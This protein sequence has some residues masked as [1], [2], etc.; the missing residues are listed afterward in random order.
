MVAIETWKANVIR[1]CVSD[2]RWFGS[3]DDQKGQADAAEAYRKIVDEAVEATE[4]RGSYLVLDLHAY[5]APTERTVAFWKDAAAR[6]KA[7][8]GVLFA[9]LNEPHDISWQVW[10]DGGE[11]TD[12]PKKTDSPAENAQPL[13]SQ[14]TV[15]MQ[16]VVEAVRSAGAKNIVIIGGLDW[17]YDLSGVAGEFALTEP[18]GNGIMYDSHVYPWKRDWAGKV[19]AAAKKYP[20]L[21]GEVGCEEKPMP[22]IPVSAHEDPYTWAPDMIG[23]IQANHLNWTA[24]SFHPGATPRVIQDWN[25][26]PTPFWGA[27]VRAALLGAKFE[28][29]KMR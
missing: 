1:L 11:V 14:Q 27:F 20:L 4:T 9:L 25:Y 12:K 19:L 26:T 2:D 29:R 21:I 3:A 13:K 23:F 15:G 7:R 16:K 8:R 22:F 18:G 5:R 28:M 17:G 6:Y 10:R 24:W